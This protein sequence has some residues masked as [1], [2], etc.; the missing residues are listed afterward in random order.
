[1][2]LASLLKRKRVQRYRSF[3]TLPT[4]FATFFEKRLFS[5]KTAVKHPVFEIFI[6]Q[7]LASHL[8][9]GG[10]N[11]QSDKFH[12]GVSKAKKAEGKGHIAFVTL[13]NQSRATIKLVLVNDETRLEMC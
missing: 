8:L 2:C 7:K 12:R 11:A 10:Q 9:P 5:L 6:L 1:M 13:K 3:S 4:F